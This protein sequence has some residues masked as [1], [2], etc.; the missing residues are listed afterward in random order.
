MFFDGFIEN[1]IVVIETGN[2]GILNFPFAVIN[3]FMIKI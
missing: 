3:I 2:I 1:W